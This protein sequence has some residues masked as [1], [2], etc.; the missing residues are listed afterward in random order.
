[1]ILIS[2]VKFVVPNFTYLKLR[3]KYIIN[4]MHLY[5]IILNTLLYVYYLTVKKFQFGYKKLIKLIVKQLKIIYIHTQFLD[6]SIV[7]FLWRTINKKLIIFCMHIFFLYSD[8]NSI[9]IR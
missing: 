5:N 2:Y 4:Y 8:R 9:D 1:M 6:Q 7:V 3:L